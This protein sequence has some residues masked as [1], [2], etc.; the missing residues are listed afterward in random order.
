VANVTLDLD[1]GIYHIN[2][3]DG[4]R[5]RLLKAHPGDIEQEKW[6][7]NEQWFVL[8]A[9]RPGVS[10]RDLAKEFGLEELRHYIDRSRRA[11]DERRG[12]EY[13]AKVLFPNLDPSDLKALTL[14]ARNTA[15]AKANG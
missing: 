3:N 13:Q 15:P 14:R 10:A 11:I 8:R 4:P 5:D 2:F 6:L 1:R 12:W 9:K 7:E